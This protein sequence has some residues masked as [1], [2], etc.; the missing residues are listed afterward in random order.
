MPCLSAPPTGWH[1]GA[2]PVIDGCGGRLGTEALRSE[3]SQVLQVEEDCGLEWLPPGT[4]LFGGSAYGQRTAIRAA[5]SSRFSYWDMI[6]LGR[7]ASGDGYEQGAGE[8]G[9]TVHIDDRPLYVDRF[10]WAADSPVRLSSWGLQGHSVFAQLLMYPADEDVLLRARQVLAQPSL[11]AV[12]L[13]N[14]TLVD[15]LLVVRVLGDASF[16]VHG[17]LQA[18]WSALRPLVMGRST[19]PPRIWAT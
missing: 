1:G 4:I 7:P 6:C 13:M 14:A 15:G 19:C 12:G 3:V 16:K 17:V 8:Q 2:G 18:V 10:S 11:L 9:L 5:G